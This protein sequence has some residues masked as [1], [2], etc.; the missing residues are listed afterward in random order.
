[1]HF[2]IR[3]NQGKNAGEV[4]NID[5]SVKRGKWAHYNSENA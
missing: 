2:S 1:M 4:F 5:V 3:Q